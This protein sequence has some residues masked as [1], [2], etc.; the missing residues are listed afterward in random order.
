MHHHLPQQYVMNP[1]INQKYGHQQQHWE[2]GA[3][4]VHHHHHHARAAAQAAAAQAAAHQQNAFAPQTTEAAQNPRHWSTD[5]NAHIYAPVQ[6]PAQAP[7]P[8]AV[9]A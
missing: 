5:P 9:P 7:P 4:A 1:N 3:A 6:A 8:Q 2:P